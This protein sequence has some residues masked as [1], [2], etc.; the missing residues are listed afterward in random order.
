MQPLNPMPGA[1]FS[2]PRR[3]SASLSA[4]LALWLSFSGLAGAQA[5]VPAPDIRQP[6]RVVNECNGLVLTEGA[7]RSDG[8]RLAVLR[9]DQW[10]PSQ[11]W[12][13]VPLEGGGY[14]LRPYSSLTHALDVQW[15]LTS[16]GTPIQTYAWN[17]TAAQRWLISPRGTGGA[18]YT[19]TSALAADRT[20]AASGLGQDAPAQLAVAAGGCAQAWRLQPAPVPGTQQPIAGREWHVAP[21]G[22]D[23]APGT[24]NA[25]LASPQLAVDR[26]RPGDHVVLQAGTYTL[27]AP[28]LVANK[29]GTAALPIVVRGEGR[30]VL[31]DASP[32][33]VFN[34]WFWGLVR[35]DDSEHVTV[36]GLTLSNSRF[37]GVRAERVRHFTVEDLVTTVTMASAIYVN[38]GS[39]VV[40][41]RNDVSRFCDKGAYG[42]GSGCQEGISISTVDGFDIAENLVHDAPQ[43]PG[44]GGGGG[45]GIDAKVGSSNGTIRNN[46]V[47]NLVQLGIYVDAWTATSSNISIYGNRVWNCANGIVIGAEAGGTVRDIRIHDN[48]VWRNGLSGIAISGAGDDGP[49]QNIAIFN[50]TVALNGYGVYKPAWAGNSDWGH[51]VYVS[52]SRVSGLTMRDNILYDNSVVQFD[53]PS[54]V[55]AQ[56]LL[57]NNLVV[58]FNKQSWTQ[59]TAGTRAILGDPRFVNPVADDFH[60][61]AA[62]PAIG[63]AI[64]VD[65]VGATDADGRPRPRAAGADLGALLFRP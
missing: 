5:L 34:N 60:L 38:T 31:R 19:L 47:W 4:V 33:T 1:I 50:N 28:L 10:L 48:L 22:N 37:F 65:P 46:R 56:V 14:V 7:A 21:T 23:G 16:P 35:V 6:M 39:N 30:P 51:G 27:S 44:V 2:R 3:G 57:D 54:A 64:G 8:V 32:G 13:V 43:Q 49:K 42:V 20:L 24:R 58:P 63:R 25:P 15:S 41:R 55:R 36:R 40:I 52:S 17:G 45:E 61:G 26:A 62:S 18:L 59:E 12:Q 29:K 9:P 11:R 53:L